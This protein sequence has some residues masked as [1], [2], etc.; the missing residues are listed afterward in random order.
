MTETKQ[1]Q[2]DEKKKSGCGCGCVSNTKKE[3]KEPKST[4]EKSKK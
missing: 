1:V 4:V 3:A 2:I